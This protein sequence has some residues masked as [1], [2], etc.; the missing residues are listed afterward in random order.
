MEGKDGVQE[1]GGEQDGLTGNRKAGIFQ[2]KSDGNRP[3]A[4]LCQVLPDEI[5]NV[6]C[7]ALGQTRLTEAAKSTWEGRG[8]CAEFPFK[9]RREQI[10]LFESAAGNC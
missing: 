6:V 2:Q 10:S 7:H 5:E 9:P 1:T 3:I 4:V 8:I